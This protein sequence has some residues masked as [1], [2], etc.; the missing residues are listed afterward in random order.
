MGFFQ[1]K[2]LHVRKFHLALAS[3]GLGT[4]DWCVLWTINFSLLQSVDFYFINV[5]LIIYNIVLG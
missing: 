5:D 1:V 4:R 3:G 2:L